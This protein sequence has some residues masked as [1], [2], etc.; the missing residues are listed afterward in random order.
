M[1]SWTLTSRGSNHSNIFDLELGYLTHV[2]LLFLLFLAMQV[3]INSILLKLSCKFS[4]IQYWSCPAS[5][6]WFNLIEVQCLYVLIQISY[7]WIVVHACTNTKKSSQTTSITNF[8]SFLKVTWTLYMKLIHINFLSF[9][10]NKHQSNHRL[11]R[12]DE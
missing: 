5:F 9:L 6:H 4:L 8:I 2:C 11:N 10:S 7:T 1:C 3:F 12:D